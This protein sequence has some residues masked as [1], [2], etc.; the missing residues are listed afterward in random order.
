MSAGGCAAE[1]GDATLPTHS[2]PL[3]PLPP[4]PLPLLIAHFI[5]EGAHLTNSAAL[6]V[7]IIVERE[8]ALGANQVHALL[9][10]WEGVLYPDAIVLLNSIKELV[11]LWIESASVQAAEPAITACQS[12]GG[13]LRPYSM[14]TR[15]TSG[16]PTLCNAV[17]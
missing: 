13:P 10:I 7:T 8:H 9:S 3:Q 14:M 5:L 1:I 2:N 15:E 16:C 6:L 4:P 11:C 12:L 17:V